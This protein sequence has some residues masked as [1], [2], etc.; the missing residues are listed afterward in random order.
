M[1]IHIAIAAIAGLL[2]K[3]VDWMDDE[4]RS[5]SPLRFIFALGYGIL[6]GFLIGEATFSAI[7]MAALVAQVFARKIDTRAHQ[8]GF[9]T[10]L[11]VLL[12]FQIPQLDLMV[13]S[14]FLVLAFLDEVDWIGKLRPL[15]RYRPFLKI[16]ALPLALIGR[17]DY[18]L[19][20]MAFDLGYEA[21][22]AL[23]R[24]IK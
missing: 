23:K 21:F 18:F 17:W 20:I 24:H 1:I 4:R 5:R 3:L 11:I 15:T 13:F 7:F 14:Y 9:V 16:G 12:F 2:V 22:N 10:S 6:I 19:G 8:L